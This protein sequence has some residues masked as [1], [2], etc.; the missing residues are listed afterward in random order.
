MLAAAHTIPIGFRV[1]GLDVAKQQQKIN[2]EMLDFFVVV[3]LFPRGI[4]WGA[5]IQ[6]VIAV[7]GMCKRQH[8]SLIEKQ[9]LL[10]SEFWNNSPVCVHLSFG[11]NI[12]DIKAFRG[13]CLM[14]TE[15]LD[16]MLLGVKEL[17]C[18]DA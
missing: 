10:E 14:I 11:C 9:Q 1:A 13:G 17:K 3:L 6:D 2:G 12:S 16:F 18:V 5:T 8:H 4:F 15:H 7:T